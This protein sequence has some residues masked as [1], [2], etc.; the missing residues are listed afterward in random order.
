MFP[1]CSQGLTGWPTLEQLFLVPGLRKPWP[2]IGGAAPRMASLS[3]PDI[4]GEPLYVSYVYPM[5]RSS[6]SLNISEHWKLVQSCV[7]LF[8][9]LFWNP[10]TCVRH[11]LFVIQDIMTWNCGLQL[12]PIGP[13]MI[14]MGRIWWCPNKSF[15]P[16]F[17]DAQFGTEPYPSHA[18]DPGGSILWLSLPILHCM[19][20]LIIDDYGFC[21]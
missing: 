17:D 21:M 9:L 19:L 15:L 16:G 2:G 10:S 20:G 7:L 14:P 4:M 3:H 12:L 5:V 6:M 1:G 18:D 13:R 8:L 11:L